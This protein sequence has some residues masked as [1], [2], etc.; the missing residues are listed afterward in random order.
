MSKSVQPG[1][2]A[3]RVVFKKNPP[4]PL[5]H[6]LHLGTTVGVALCPCQDFRSESVWTEKEGRAP[7]GRTGTVGLEDG[8]QTWRMFAVPCI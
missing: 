1:G 4:A 7:E 5:L 8:R 6:L 3:P 2:Q